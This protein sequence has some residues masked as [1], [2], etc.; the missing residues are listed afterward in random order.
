MKCMCNGF[1]L[2]LTP[3]FAEVHG[4]GSG[5]SSYSLRKK[6]Q[7]LRKF[8]IIE[9]ESFITNKHT[10]LQQFSLIFVS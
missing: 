2:K 1:S 8:I 10:Y 6:K 4:S 3:K 5:L 7:L 9:R